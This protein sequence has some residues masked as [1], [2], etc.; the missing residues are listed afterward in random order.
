M[1]RIKAKLKACTSKPYQD[2]DLLY[3]F[4]DLQD[5]PNNSK[6]F[7][8]DPCHI[9]KHPLGIIS[10]CKQCGLQCSIY[11]HI[12]NLGNPIVSHHGSRCGRLID[13]MYTA[14]PGL[15]NIKG[16]SIVQDTGGSSDHDLVITKMDLGI[17]Q[18]HIN[19]EKEELI[20]LKEL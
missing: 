4:R 3:I 13:R 19:K 11:Q 8:Y 5:Q 7:H 10:K 2:S 17:E 6:L 16:I 1:T 20:F 14:T 9:A 18:Y 12:N 15:A